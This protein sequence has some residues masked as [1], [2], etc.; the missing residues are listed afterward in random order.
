MLRVPRAKLAGELLKVFQNLD[1]N[2]DGV[3]TRSELAALMSELDCEIW[4]DAKVRVLMDQIDTNRDGIIEYEDL[5]AWFMSSLALGKDKDAVLSTKK[6]VLTLETLMKLVGDHAAATLIDRML[7]KLFDCYD[8]D[9]DGMIERLEFLATEEKKRRMSGNFEPITRSDRQAMI[10][11]FRD[12]GAEGDLVKGLYLDKESF[13]K[14][15][16]A[17]AKQQSG[18][19]VE[20]FEEK[21]EEQLARWIWT[22]LCEVLIQGEDVRNVTGVTEES[23]I[24][25][26]GHRVFCIRFSP[27]DS[28]IAAGFDNGDVKVY[29]VVDHREEYLL[30]APTVGS[31]MPITSLRWRP[32]CWD[33]DIVH[34]VLV[35]VG[36]DGRIRHWNALTRNILHETRIEDEELFCL[37]FRPD[38]AQYAVAGKN[39]VVYVYDEETMKQAFQMTGLSPEDD[40]RGTASRIFSLKWHPKDAN[41]LITGGWDRM[42]KIWDLAPDVRMVVRTINGPYVAGD[43]VDIS[44]DGK[45][46]L[47]GSASELGDNLQL[48]HYESGDLIDSNDW[49]AA[50]NRPDERRDEEY[51]KPCL[52]YTAQFSKHDGSRLVLAGGSNASE[53]RVFRKKKR[54]EVRGE[55]IL[56]ESGGWCQA[57]DFS[58]DGEY[59]AVGTGKGSV[60]LVRTI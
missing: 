6:Y 12:A 36:S 40:P 42:V 31:N 22:H 32:T 43:T 25:G 3:V 49:R 48:W 17:V 54:W 8:D 52:L 10:Q 46:L 19:S 56:P 30:K 28:Y 59:I 11:W 24:P 50:D 53:V 15:M 37:D 47:T 60:R 26:I 29:A 57:A 27:D 20:E 16:I 23:L 39:H 7:D 5:V 41:V 33:T 13:K 1:I 45:V 9:E 44:Y 14:A 21:Y 51:S 38:G 58:H 35:A 4:T 34:H 2:K 55:I 18:I